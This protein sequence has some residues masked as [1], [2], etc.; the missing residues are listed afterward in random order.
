[1]ATGTHSDLSSESIWTTDEELVLETGVDYRSGEPVQVRLRR[2]GNR[3]HLDDGG[4]AVQHAG[5]PSGWLDVAERVVAADGFNINRRGV[6]FVAVGRGRDLAPLA[7]R[8]SDTS[9]GVY[10]ALLDLQEISS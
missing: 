8:L 6:V 5:R 2:R 7:L 10:L 3:V 1:V 9:L 4:N